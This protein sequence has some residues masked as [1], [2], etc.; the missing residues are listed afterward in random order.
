MKGFKGK[1]SKE[2]LTNIEAELEK[3]ETELVA[4]FEKEDMAKAQATSYAK[5]VVMFGLTMCTA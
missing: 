5:K 1:I 2:L 4:L 3:T